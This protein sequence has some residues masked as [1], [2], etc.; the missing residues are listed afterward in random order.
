MAG[1]MEKLVYLTIQCYDVLSV[2]VGKSFVSIL[3]ADL[4]GIRGWKCNADQVII[5]QTIIL[6]RARFETCD[7]NI[8]AQINT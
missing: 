1:G 7:K 2:W 5:F 6:Q 4:D 3:A 8:C